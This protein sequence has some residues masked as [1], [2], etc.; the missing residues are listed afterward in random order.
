M[1]T[2]L[3]MCFC[4]CGY[5]LQCNAQI[6][7]VTLNGGTQYTENGCNGIVESSSISPPNQY[8]CY[9]GCF[10]N[11]RSM[12]DQTG[13]GSYYDL[14]PENVFT[15][16]SYND[17]SCNA[18]NLTTVDLSN[19]A[20]NACF[21]DPYSYKLWRKQS[22]TNS[23]YMLAYYSDD[24]CQNISRVIA[25]RDLFLTCTK[26]NDKWYIESCHSPTGPP[27]TT[28]LPTTT[29]P[30]SASPTSVSPTNAALSSSS[31][32]SNLPTTL[33]TTIQPGTVISTT[34]SST[35]SSG[36]YHTPCAWI[37]LVAFICV[38]VFGGIY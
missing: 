37:V 29:S 9:G 10:S 11:T 21:Y 36:A 1:P 15:R 12:C 8:E 17:A 4:L 33:D 7:D 30:T 2:I 35:P 6:S 38:G 3:C 19:V 27:P 14:Y 23:T 18:A 13:L 32:I 22:C 24:Q 16:E 5:F 26:E 20:D 25:S 34:S 31:Q 28:S